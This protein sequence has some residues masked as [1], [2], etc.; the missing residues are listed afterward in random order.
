MTTDVAAFFNAQT[1]LQL[2]PIF[3][4]YLRHAAIPT[5]ELKFDD[6]AHT[7]SYRWS[8]EEKDFA[9]PIKVGNSSNWQIVQ[10]STAEWKVLSTPLTKE[11]FEVATD[12]YYV[13]VHKQ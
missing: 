13:N 1:G 12:L 4:E 7:V 9:M 11:N 5:L 6:T 8:A 10:P 2:T 3:N